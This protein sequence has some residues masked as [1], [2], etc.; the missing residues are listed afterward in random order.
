MYIYYI[1]HI[2]HTQCVDEW[3]NGKDNCPICKC[4]VDINTNIGNDN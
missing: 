3:L 2:F 4:K 1:V